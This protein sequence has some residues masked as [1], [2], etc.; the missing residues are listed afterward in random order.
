MRESGLKCKCCKNRTS[1]QLLRL[2]YYCRQFWR[3]LV[4]EWCKKIPAQHYFRNNETLVLL[5]V[6]F[7]HVIICIN[8]TCFYSDFSFFQEA[9]MHTCACKRFIMSYHAKRAKRMWNRTNTLTP[10]IYTNTTRLGNSLWS[11]RC[12]AGCL[13]LVTLSSF[14]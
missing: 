2:R 4:R 10:W 13:T 7:C 14:S 8:F 3:D 9:L 1:R 12:Y 5:D 11:K 6:P